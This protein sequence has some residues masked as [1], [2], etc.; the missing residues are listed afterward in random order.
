MRRADED[1]WLAARFAPARARAHLNALCAL[2]YEIARTAESV[3]QAPLG[4]IRLA[5]WREAIDEIYA[6]KTP[7]AHP[8]VQAFAAAVT[9]AGPPREPIE[10]LIAARA[11][12]LEP[13]PFATWADL[14]R[15]VDATAGGVIRVALALCGGANEAFAASAGKAWGYAG[16]VR[17]APFWKAR[18][19][20]LAP[21]D[22]DAARIE[23]DLRARAQVALAEARAMAPKLPD[24]LFPAYGYVALV[25]SYLRRAQRPLL[26]RQLTLIAAAATGRL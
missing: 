20:V 18:G 13:A 8:T 11:A 24:T 25:S 19:R 16:L 10:A 21:R 12:D 22:A 5:W 26:L 14:E 23:S 6:G 15:Y 7:R 9:E 2:N 1:R 3:T 17:V 4:D